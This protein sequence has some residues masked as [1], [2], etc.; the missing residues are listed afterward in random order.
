METEGGGEGV[1]RGGGGGG[2]AKPSE[3]WIDG[4]GSF[5]YPEAVKGEQWVDGPQE[6]T[7]HDA[8]KIEGVRSE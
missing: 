3:L 8:E 7:Q 6:F 2:G 4:P 1:E 5:L